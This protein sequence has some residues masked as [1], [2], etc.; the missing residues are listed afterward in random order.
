MAKSDTFLKFGK[1]T[2]AMYA[3]IND[4]AFAGKLES[5]HLFMLAVS[6]GFSSG[7]RERDFTRASTGPRTNIKEEH[8]AMLSSIHMA[9]SD[10]S[11]L[12]D[13]AERDRVSEEFAQGGI[14]LLHEKLLDPNVSFI[15]W[16]V[17]EMRNGADARS[18]SE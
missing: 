12:T 18:A 11:S 3:E 9:V 15:S 17:S 6:F 13:Q 1:D 5:I 14:R 10:V 8:L 16:L 4:R 2:E 7:R